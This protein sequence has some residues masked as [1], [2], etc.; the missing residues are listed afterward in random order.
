MTRPHLAAVAAAVGLET[1]PTSGRPAWVSALEARLTA[2]RAD[3]DV[4]RRR[5]CDREASLLE[6][7][8]TELATDL[9][10]RS[11]EDALLTIEQAATESGY[12]TAGVRKLLTRG[13]VPN[14]GQPFKPRIRRGDLLP[15]ARTTQEPRP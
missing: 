1:V 12:S 3:A 2:W 9:A 7:C 11:V 4:L 6:A 10:V 5:G 13:D 15:F 14:R 8:A